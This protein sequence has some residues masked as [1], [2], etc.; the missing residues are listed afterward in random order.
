MRSTISISTRGGSSNGSPMYHDRYALW[1]QVGQ[2]SVM[3]A[4]VRGGEP[5]PGSE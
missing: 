5:S 3:S 2:S 4:R 1:A